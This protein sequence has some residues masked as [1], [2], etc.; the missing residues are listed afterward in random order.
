MAIEGSYGYRGELLIQRRVTAIFAT[1]VIT[2]YIVTCLFL[3]S[4]QRGLLL[5]NGSKFTMKW[6]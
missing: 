3:L 2:F 5:L 1:F 4:P 6:Q